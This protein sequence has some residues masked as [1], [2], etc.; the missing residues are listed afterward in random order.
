MKMAYGKR[1]LRVY[2]V[3]M[4]WCICRCVLSESKGFKDQYWDVVPFPGFP[5]AREVFM[6]LP[7][8]ACC[9]AAF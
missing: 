8:G 7:S 9:N 4:W 6:K 3:V 1:C 2:D 5:G